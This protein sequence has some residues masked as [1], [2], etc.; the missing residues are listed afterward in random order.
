[1]FN[2]NMLIRAGV[3]LVHFELGDEPFRQDGFDFE[4]TPSRR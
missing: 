2:G 4:I 1:M 3:A